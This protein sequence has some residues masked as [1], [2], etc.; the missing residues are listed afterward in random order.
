M[1]ISSGANVLGGV[2]ELMA[3][4]MVLNFMKNAAVN[5]RHAVNKMSRHQISTEH[6]ENYIGQLRIIQQKIEDKFVGL[7]D[8]AWKT[9]QRCKDIANFN[10]A[11][12]R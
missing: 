6:F 7:H 12:V 10:R 9:E 3:M 4:H 11:T 1:E 2:D 5:M 8:L